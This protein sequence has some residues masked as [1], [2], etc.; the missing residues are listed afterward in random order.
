MLQECQEQY[1]R[2][3]PF[4]LFRKPN[5][6]QV[7]TL[8]QKDA[9]L[10]KVSDYKE[11]GFVFATFMGNES[12][13]LPAT[14][15][16]VI[17]R[18]FE[19]KLRSLRALSTEEIENET[20]KV[21]HTN[22]VKKGISHIENGDFSKVVLSRRETLLIN[23]FDFLDTFNKLAS[24]Y[25]SAFAYCFY[26]PK[27]GL[28]LGAFSEQLIFAKGRNFRTM[29]VAGSQLYVENAPTFWGS[30]EVTEQQ[31]VTDFIFSNLSRVSSEIHVS[32][33]YTL[34]AGN[35][36]HI[37]TDITGTFN[38][39]MQLKDVL[40]ILHPTP[41]VCGFPK[42]VALNFIV[43]NEGY[44]RRFYAGFL[45]ELNFDFESEEQASDLYVNLRCMEIEDNL[46]HIYIGGGIT[47]DS[48][49]ESEWQ[50]TVN[51]SQTIKNILF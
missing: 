43:A 12:F 19:T 39:E 2:K 1:A 5:S 44:D 23:D 46:A 42:D 27:V 20:K 8:L 18:T 14:E 32:E 41:A 7:I 11:K 29:A 35:L 37:K 28:W 47:V 33:P 6:D 49:A 15:C 50:E 36:A 21:R 40:S 13:I 34:R 45:G 24:A 26:H 25:T 38:N 30:K 51:K 9:T 4:V 16:Q 10:H 22:L 48:D 17:I 31:L 3:L